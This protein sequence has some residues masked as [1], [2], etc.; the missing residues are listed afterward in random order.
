MVQIGFKTNTAQ[1]I[2]RIMKNVKFIVPVISFLL[3]INGNIAV[4]QI[5]SPFDTLAFISKYRESILNDM[6]IHKNSGYAVA[7]FDNKSVLW[8]ECFGLST[9]NKKVNDEMLF[10]IQS[11]SKN[12]TAL[13]MMF[14]LQ[15][16]LI[17][18]DSAITKY[19][20]DF[21]VNSCFEQNPQK[22]IT[23]RLLLTHAAGLTHEAPV[24]NNYN[25]KF[26]S[27]DDHY[28]SIRNTWLKFPV[29][30][31]S[32][33]SNLGFDL[34]AQIIERVS[35]M[36]FSEYIKNKIFEPLS[37]TFTTTDEN[38]IVAN[39]NRT[40]GIARAQTEKHIKIPLIGSGAV[41]SN[42]NDMIKYVQFQMNYGNTGDRQ[43]LAK[44]YLYEMYSYGFGT[45][46]SR[47]KE[48]NTY[49]LGHSGGGF[50]FTSDM[51]WSSDSKIGC[52]ILHNMDHIS[53]G[54]FTNQFG[55]IL[56]KDYI[57]QNKNITKDTSFFNKGFKTVKVLNKYYSDQRNNQLQVK[58]SPMDS[59]YK[60]E[61]KKYIGKYKVITGWNFKWY[62]RLATTFGYKI[63]PSEIVKKDDALYLKSDAIAETKL[64][65]YLPGLFF[66]NAGEAL[67][68]RNKVPTYGNIELKKYK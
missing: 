48:L 6:K 29:G 24:G 18:L 46:N 32:S 56:V 10:S 47:N 34:A 13:A 51:R 64:K 25:F 44:K 14:A 45:G 2:I 42:I 35:G 22:K 65:E 19:L 62:A 7:V 8:K 59:I 12:F 49:I 52:V 5:I 53:G 58:E 68:F 27:Y 50:G 3:S 38:E 37:M 11:T 57:A 17:D 66:T 20:P 55:S 9:Y 54:T 60:E 30:S 16:G 40:E 39:K 63:Y 33:Y 43:L 67:D 26:N 61:W 36:S 1:I 4:S 31:K 15:D 21:K 23:I 28:N 41:Y